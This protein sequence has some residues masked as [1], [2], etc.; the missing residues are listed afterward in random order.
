MIA[1]NVAGPIELKV[2]AEYTNYATVDISHDIMVAVEDYCNINTNVMMTH[3]NIDN[4]VYTLSR[5]DTVILTHDPF[6]A[7]DGSNNNL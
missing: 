1:D 7:S 2:I 3:S 5:A 4:Q 6:T